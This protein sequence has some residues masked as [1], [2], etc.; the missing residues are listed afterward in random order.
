MAFHPRCSHCGKVS[1]LEAGEAN[2]GCEYRCPSCGKMFTIHPPDARAAESSAS[3]ISRPSPAAPVATRVPGSGN[4]G[5][6]TDSATAKQRDYIRALGGTAT[7]DLT[8]ARASEII[9]ELDGKRPPTKQQ[10]KFI[11]MLG[12]DVP[13]TKRQAS[14]VCDLL[15][16]TALATTQQRQRAQELGL[17]LP[18]AATFSQA[19]ELLAP[20][21]LDADEVEGKPPTKAQLNKIVR[22]GGDPQK[23]SSRW[24]ADEY[25]EE[26]EER[27]QEE[28]EE[29]ADRVDEAMDWVFGDAD[30]R[31]MMSVRKPAKA[32][33]RK[34][35][36]FGDSQG[37]GDY[38]ES[39]DS[40]S[41][42]DSF[43]LVDFALYSVAPELL[44]PG[45]PLP[46]MPR[47]GEYLARQSKT[48]C[49]SMLVL[50]LLLP[51]LAWWLA[52]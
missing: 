51:V 18:A 43:A 2:I 10:V 37:W 3:R 46:R 21:E 15:S 35:L 40:T 13:P 7:P 11:K 39:V 27:R 32:T 45:K 6:D 44:K 4:P 47:K 17:A 19:K 23:P 49:L 22:L 5:P 41:E 42:L 1:P 38:W 50:A 24:R 9:S 14:Q 48:G 12:G 16:K 52:V 20:A 30:G 34:A 36:L 26:C 29:L 33:M 25:I 8:K 28:Q 31:A